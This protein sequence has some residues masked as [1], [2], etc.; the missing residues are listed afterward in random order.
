MARALRTREA[1]L[2]EV[3]HGRIR[4][5]ALLTTRGRFRRRWSGVQPRKSSRGAR[6]HDPEL[7]YSQGA[8]RQRDGFSRL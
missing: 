1:R 2:G 3:I 8:R 7:K 6:F 4:K 5:R